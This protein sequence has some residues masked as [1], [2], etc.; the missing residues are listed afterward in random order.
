MLMMLTQVFQTIAV[1]LKHC[2]AYQADGN[3]RVGCD[4]DRNE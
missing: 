1:S 4:G 2:V 3:V